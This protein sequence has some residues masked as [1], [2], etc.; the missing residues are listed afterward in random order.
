MT[1]DINVMTG[2]RNDDV[3]IDMRFVITDYIITVITCNND[4]K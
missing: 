4:V 3:I 2:I 1:A